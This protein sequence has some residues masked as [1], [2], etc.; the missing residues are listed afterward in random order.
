V[1]VAQYARCPLAVSHDHPR[2]MSADN[3]LMTLSEAV[4]QSRATFFQGIE[5][6]EAGRLIEARACFERCQ[7]LTPDRP[8]VL[9]NLGVT[10]FR[11]G[12]LREALPLLRQATVGEPGFVDAWVCLGLAHEAQGEWRSAV[13]ALQHALTLLPKERSATLHLAL[14][15]CLMRLGKLNDALPALDRA[16]AADPTLAEAWSVRGGLLREL[17][18]LDAAA[19]SYEQA[20]THGADRELHAYYLASVRDGATSAPPARAPRSYVEGLFDDYAADFAGHVV[21]QLGYRAHEAL[22]APVVASGRRFRHALDLGCGTGLCAPLLAP[23]CDAIDGVDLSSAMLAQARKLG[24]YH[25]LVHADIGEFLAAATQ[26]MDLV[27]AAD[28]MIYVGELSGVLRHVARL[29]EP[30]GVFVFTVELP[31]SAEREL[32]LLPSLRY[33]H[34]AAYV[35]RLATACGL[36]VDE[37]R[38]APIRYEQGKPVPGL[39][40]TLSVS[41]GRR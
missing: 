15:Q 5:H 26:P 7:A 14:G 34:S 25:E 1:V 24:L 6:F 18:R 13:T 10:L 21:E 31:A 36:V 11:M 23:V 20:L 35:Q 29:L 30:G 3:G 19:H 37:M 16:V 9:G 32:Q 2:V 12:Q 22:L 27:L 8:S 28:V 33:A 4:E 39:Y 17:H 38:A 40:V 41:R